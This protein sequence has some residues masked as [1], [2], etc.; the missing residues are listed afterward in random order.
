MGCS[1]THTLRV[2]ITYVGGRTETVD[3]YVS[4]ENAG[5]VE[6]VQSAVRGRLVPTFEW[7]TGH[8]DISVMGIEGGLWT[9]ELRGRGE[10]IAVACGTAPC[11]L[12]QGQ[13]IEAVWPALEHT[14][15]EVPR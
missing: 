6:I 8:L 5:Q 4:A 13:R 1:Q 9:A 12:K 3:T 15:D 2:T 10:L 14:R 7:E 11:Q